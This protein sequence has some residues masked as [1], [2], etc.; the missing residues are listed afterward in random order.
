MATRRILL[1]TTNPAKLEHLHWLLAGLDLEPLSPSEA[2]LRLDVAETGVTHLA[3]AR[4]KARA[5]SHAFGGLALASDGG[6][7]VPALGSGWDSLRTARFAGPDASDRQ[8]VE[9][10]LD[11]MRP[12]RGEERRACWVEALSLADKGAVVRSWR[13]RSRPGVIARTFRD[14]DLVPGFWAF[15]VWEFPTLG[16]RYADLTPDELALVD[17]HWTRLRPAVRRFLEW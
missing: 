10:L 3:V 13:R 8:R 7:V 4:Q 17:D 15:S 12:L 14:E 5:W 9:A 6:L 11:M 16:K 1:A 2:G